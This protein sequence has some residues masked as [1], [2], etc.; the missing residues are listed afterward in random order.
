MAMNKIFD[1]HCHLSSDDYD[2]LEEIV[3]RTV[4]DKVTMIA[5]CSDPLSEKEGKEFA[6][7]Y[8]GSIYLTIG[9]H[10][11]TLDVNSDDLTR[12]SNWAKTDKNVI[13]IGEI[14]LD[15]YWKPYDES[16]Q[17]ELFEKQLSMAKKLNLPVVIHSR[18]ATKQTIDTLKKYDLKGV[19]HCFTGSIET[20]R[21]YIKLGFYLGIGGVVTFK[22]AGLQETVRQLPI[23]S[24]VLE[25]DSPYL[26]PEPYRGKKNEPRNVR[27]VAKKIAELKGL[28]T[29]EVIE[30]TNKNTIQLFDLN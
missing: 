23:E 14:G 20:A 26:A 7:K 22:N 3:T 13:A 28:S 25:T 30:I 12:I 5:S 27:L 10:P 9:Y 8:P 29:E 21:E 11:S 2:N 15:Y 16:Y 24:I 4:E 18:D 6:E 19:I 1:T 17:Q